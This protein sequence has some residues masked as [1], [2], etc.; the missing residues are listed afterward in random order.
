MVKTSR[1]TAVVREQ[2]MSQ[3]NEYTG[4]QFQVTDILSDGEGAISKLSNELAARGIIVNRAGPGQHV[5]VIENKIRQFKERVR[6]VLHSLPYTLPASFMQYLCNF[7]AFCLNV[8]PSHTRM[9]SI[10]PREAF[11]GRKLNA[12]TDLRV[13]FGEYVQ[14]TVP[15][16]DNS[17]KERTD[18]AIA[19]YPSGNPDG[20]WYF[21]NLKTQRVFL[22]NHWTTI[23]MDSSVVEHMNKLAANQKRKLRPEPRFSYGNDIIIDGIFDEQADAEDDQQ[24]PQLKTSEGF[25][26][27]EQEFEVEDPTQETPE[28]HRDDSDVSESDPQDDQDF[29]HEDHRGATPEHHHRGA[30]Y[31]G[32]QYQEAEAQ[33][34]YDS[35]ETFEDD[36][37]QDN[38]NEDLQLEAN[39]PVPMQDTL[40]ADPPEGPSQPPGAQTDTP[41]PRYNLRKRNKIDYK[42]THNGYVIKDMQGWINWTHRQCRIRSINWVNNITPAK[43]IRLFG[44]KAMEALAKE[45]LQLHDRNVFEPVKVSKLSY[46]QLKAIIRSKIFLKEKYLS[47][48]EFDKLKARLVA[49]G[50][51]QDKTIY[52]KSSISSPTPTQQSVFGIAS[53]AAAEHRTVVTADIPGAYLNADMDDQEVL[54]RLNKLEAEILCKHKPEYDEYI[55]PNGTM[56][57]KLKKALYGL[58]QSAKLWY[59]CLRSSLEEFGFACNPYDVC[60]FNKTVNG[61]QITVCV[62]VDDLMITSANNKA[63][64]D[65][66]KSLNKK[67]GELTVKRGDVH[68]YLGMTFD[69]SQEGEVRVTMEGYIKDMLKEYEVTGKAAS[70]ALDNLFKI[71]NKSKRLSYDQQEMFHSRVAKLLYLAKRAMPELLPAI[72]FLATRVNEATEEDLEKLN[73]TLKYINGAQHHGICLKLIF[74]KGKIQILVYTDASWKSHAD[75]KG[76]T[77]AFISLGLGPVYIRCSKQKLVTK[78]SAEAELLALSD[79]TSIVMWMRE[80]YREQGYKVKTAIVYQDN[81]SCIKLTENGRSNSDRTRHIKLHHFFMKEQIDRGEVKLVYLPTKDMIADILTKPLNGELFRKLRAKLCNWSEPNSEGSPHERSPLQGCVAETGN[82]SRKGVKTAAISHGK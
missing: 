4:H 26:D 36:E 78:S 45:L 57:V 33:E 74:V 1:S 10:S 16:P 18:G 77:G 28:H 8:V 55:E 70:P 79:M 49:G 19:L 24:E 71:D 25:Q 63:I 69:F 68:S 27:S 35:T 11:S 40:P 34:A 20:G 82:R 23:P 39:E 62:Y 56:V 51:M 17:M 76:H 42:A 58:V 13:S 32:D 72:V 80:F 2:L 53:I 30:E 6:A 52:S 64:K 29:D 12:K 31:R 41:I 54:V 46:K 50:H 73:R 15:D 65:L 3:I 37:D 66:L 61:D 75:C 38:F 59:Q 47:N 14:A 21:F 43:A 7:V 81:M 44:R 5:P 60:V 48:G 67:Y 9:D 22:R